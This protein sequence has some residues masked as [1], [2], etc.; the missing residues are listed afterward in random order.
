MGSNDVNITPREIGFAHSVQHKGPRDSWYSQ[1]IKP[2][3]VDWLCKILIRH[4]T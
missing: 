4:I 2:K 1:K 3:H